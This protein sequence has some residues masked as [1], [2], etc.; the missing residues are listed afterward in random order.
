ML[1]TEYLRNKMIDKAV[2]RA[3]TAAR[4]LPGSRDVA[5]L[6]TQTLVTAQQ[7]DAA[8]P[9][10]KDWRNNSLDDP[11]DAD[12]S[13][14]FIQ[15]QLKKYD[16]AFKQLQPWKNRIIAAADDSPDPLVLYATLLIRQN[17]TDEALNIIWPFVQKG[18]PWIS[19]Y[20][21]MAEQMPSA[22]EAEKWVNRVEPLSKSDMGARSIVVVEYYKIAQS[23]GKKSDFQRV[24]DLA[25]S[26][27]ENEKFNAS[28]ISMVA[29]ANQVVGENDEAERLY[30]LVIKRVPDNSLVM[31]NLA[32]LLY[33]QNKSDGDAEKFSR[34]AVDIAKQYRFN[35]QTRANFIE[36][37]GLILIRNGKWN[38]AVKFLAEGKSLDIDSIPVRLALIEAY[39]GQGDTNKFNNE[40]NDLDRLLQQTN[41]AL[42]AQQS[43]R[44]DAVKKQFNKG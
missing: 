8:L 36:T 18:E 15:W 22:A 21:R 3:Q 30:R 12:M 16:E 33:E 7:Y 5:K 13:I 34:Q 28:A 24:I 6:A 38:D 44:L 31:N 41:R 20:A 32:Y 2:Q 25:S 43:K 11:F 39:L 1:T 27:V 40:L 17:R 19:S 37:L 14:G 4:M 23:T 35:N 9:Y 26:D 29:D 10:A 42:S